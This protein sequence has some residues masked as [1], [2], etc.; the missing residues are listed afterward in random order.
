MPTPHINAESGD[1]AKTILLPG[2]PLRAKHIAET[3]LE[4]VKQ[5]ND[6]RNMLAFTG[7]YKGQPVSTMGSGMGI[8]SASIYYKE[9]ITEFGVE[10]LIRV[11]SCGGI[12]EAVG[13]RDVII[14]IGAG[15]DSMVNRYRFGGYDFAA[16]AD[17]GLVKAAVDAA[18]AKG[19]EVFVGNLFSSDLFYHPREGHFDIL[20]KMGILAVEMEAAGLY[21]VCAEFGAKGLTIATVSDHIFTGAETSSDDRETTFNDMVEIALEAALE[22][23][24]A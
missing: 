7:T 23:R 10:N 5:V 9:L 8:P 13:I 20:K 24:G 22:K 17:F 3:F 15:T 6:V 2:D 16:I 14:G 19:I 12:S 21:G 1:F 18:Q 4:E 11:G